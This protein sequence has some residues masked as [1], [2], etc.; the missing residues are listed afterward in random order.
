MDK[1]NYTEYN[2]VA[3]VDLKL[4]NCFLGQQDGYMILPAHETVKIKP[5]TEKLAFEGGIVA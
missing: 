2:L 5:S 4:V 3:Y 1:V